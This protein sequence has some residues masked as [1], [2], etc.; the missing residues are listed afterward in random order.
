MPVIADIDRAATAAT[1]TLIKYHVSFA[2]VIPLPILKAMPNVLVLSFAEMASR[3]GMD[4]QN[5]ISTFGVDNRDVVTTVTG[6][7]GKLRYFVAYN[8]RLPFYMLQR[9][10]ARELGHIVLQHDGSRPEDVRQEEALFF[11]RHFLCPR[12]LIKA[13]RDTIKPLTI[14]T[15]GN[16]TGC[17]ERCLLGIRRTPGAHVPAELNR[18]VKAQFADYISNFLDCQTI[19]TN[20]D[21]TD[22]ADFG[23]FMD[24][25]QE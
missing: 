13:L 5:V 20:N 6:V 25:Y 11:A 14:E 23:T 3:I 2:P 24:N 15:V 8:Q 7:G 18:A 10:L 16:V 12:P 21:I 9:S 17:Y 1:E 19:L 22:V 4:R